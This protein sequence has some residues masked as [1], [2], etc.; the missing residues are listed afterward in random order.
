MDRLYSWEAGVISLEAPPLFLSETHVSAKRAHLLDFHRRHLGFRLYSKL[1]VG[2][3]LRVVGTR[4]HFCHALLRG[5]EESTAA[6]RK[7]R[8]F[9]R[10]APLIE[11]DG[12][13]QIV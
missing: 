10:E 9:L 8:C 7:A 5:S 6:N 3:T 4:C 11:C 2:F 13:S 12:K 1:P